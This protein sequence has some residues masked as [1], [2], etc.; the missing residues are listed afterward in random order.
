ML[1]N[2]ISNSSLLFFYKFGLNLNNLAQNARVLQFPVQ[3][4]SALKYDR[5]PFEAVQNDVQWDGV[6]C[7]DGKRILRLEDGANFKGTF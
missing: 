1:E 5:M 3:N 4:Q 7:V 6:T 2:Q